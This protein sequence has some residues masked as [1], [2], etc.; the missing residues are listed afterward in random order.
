MRSTHRPITLLALLAA[1]VLAGASALGAN[2]QAEAAPADIDLVPFNNG[3]VPE[4]MGQT[5]TFISGVANI[6]TD[7]ANNVKMRFQLQGVKHTIVAMPAQ[8]TATGGSTS[9]V[10]N[11]QMGRI[12]GGGQAFLAF[13]VRY[14]GP[15]IIAVTTIADPGSR[16]A[17]TDEG[18]NVLTGGTDVIADADLYA[19]AQ[20]HGSDTQ[21]DAGDKAHVVF[22][23]ENEGHSVAQDIVVDVRITGGVPVRFVESSIFF[24]NGGTCTVT[25]STSMKCYLKRLAGTETP[26][27]TNADLNF[28]VRASAD[29]PGGAQIQGAIVAT[30]A[31][32]GESGETDFSDNQES[33][34]MTVFGPV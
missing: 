22:H 24:E 13:T 28:D 1:I 8:C 31:A 10:I 23:I 30:V 11:C 12:P 21:V 9:R 33:S 5:I 4:Y 17:E 26:G 7:A 34:P 20:A 6:G 25:S 27:D 16:I 18:N 32:S 2:R 15:G 3:P 14:Q 29:V 19:D